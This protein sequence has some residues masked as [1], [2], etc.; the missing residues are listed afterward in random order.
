MKK[1]LLSAIAFVMGLTSVQ[2]QT[3]TPYILSAVGDNTYYVTMSKEDMQA[4]FPAEWQGDAVWNM[5]IGF[6]E[7][8]VLYENDDFKATSALTLCCFWTGNWYSQEVEEKSDLTGYMNL[9][10]T[11]AQNNWTPEKITIQDVSDLAAGKNHGLIIITPKKAGKLS[12]RVYAGSKTRS[13]GIYQL[14]TDEEKDNDNFGSLVAYTNFRNDGE[15]GTV[16]KAPVDC[17]ADITT[18]HDYALIA[19]NPANISFTYMKYVPTDGGADGINDVKDNTA[20]TVVAV[21]NASGAQMNGMQNGLN[22]V[23]YSDGTTAK[24]MK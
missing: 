21:F 12:Y 4:K 15:N 10:S 17:E 11:L 1:T 5:G 24:V 6:P 7:G 3:E 8:T 20:K 9:G 14:A 23:K 19:G 13:I 22:I 2:A 18:G 16:D